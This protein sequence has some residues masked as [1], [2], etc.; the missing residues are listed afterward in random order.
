MH[1]ARQ[2]IIHVSNLVSCVNSHHTSMHDARHV[3]L[4]HITAL[5]VHV[6][7]LATSSWSTSQPSP[8]TCQPSFLEMTCVVV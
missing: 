4:V 8:S 1:R 2:I 3:I 5:V 7:T 6:S